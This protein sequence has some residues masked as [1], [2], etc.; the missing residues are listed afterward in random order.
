VFGTF[1][2]RSSG[3]SADQCTSGNSRRCSQRTGHNAARYA[4]SGCADDRTGG[5]AENV[6]TKIARAIGIIFRAETIKDF[7]YRR[8]INNVVDGNKGLSLPD[9]FIVKVGLGF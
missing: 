7:D 1:A 4:K 2:R 5:H 8:G 9:R 6:V 3:S